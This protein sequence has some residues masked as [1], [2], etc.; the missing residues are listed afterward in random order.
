M[1]FPFSGE[2]VLIKAW[3]YGLGIYRAYFQ[4]YGSWD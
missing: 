3:G 4:V 1:G 2:V